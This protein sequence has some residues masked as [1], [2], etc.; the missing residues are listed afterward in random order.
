M[1]RLNRGTKIALALVTLIALGF[2]YIPLLVI[3]LNSFNAGR[4]AGWPIP[5]FSLEWWGKALAN[6]AVHAAL[7]NSVVVALIATAF[8]LVLGTLAAF[9]LQ[10]FSFFGQHTVNL[11]IV[12]PITLPGIVTGVALSNTFH[13][14]LKPMGINV[15]YWG[16]IIAHATFCV[17]M[18]FNNVIARLRRMNPNL[19]EASMDLG[20]G[21]AQ[22][23][24]LVTFPQFRSAFIAGGLLAFALSFD[25]IVVTIFTAPPGVETLPLWIMNQMA[26]P[27]EVN[28]VNVI[29]TVMILLSLIPVYFSQKASA[30][31][32]AK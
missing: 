26:R 16:M 20:A 9:A 18:V 28:Q 24:R 19:E 23:F 5:G 13:Q 31:G 2:M 25:E 29:A 1:L 14:V 12:L 17:V 7:L 3:I 15:G 8:A 27:N 11:L 21:I 30:A 22:T 32:D 4:V 6:P 10:R